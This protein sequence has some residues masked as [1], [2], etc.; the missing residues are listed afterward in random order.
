M[1][2]SICHLNHSEL[3]QVAQGCGQAALWRPS[4]P[5]ACQESSLVSFNTRVPK[6]MGR[7]LGPTDRT[8]M[9]PPGAGHAEGGDGC[10]LPALLGGSWGLRLI[11]PPPQQPSRSA[12]VSLSHALLPPRTQP[13]LGQPLGPSCVPPFP[14]AHC[15]N[16]GRRWAAC[17]RSGSGHVYLIQGWI[18]HSPLS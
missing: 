18:I 10:F 7:S 12:R 9:A 8:R 3:G 14:Q 4:A 5:R 1:G 11:P 17:F 16:R 13:W 15:W 2:V 6:P